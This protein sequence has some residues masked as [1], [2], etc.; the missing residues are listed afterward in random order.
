M[1]TGII[2]TLGKVEKIEI[3]G[4]NIN[5]HILSLFKNQL[6]I[7]QSIAHNGVCLTITKFEDYSYVVTAVQETLFKTN[8]GDLIIGSEV[9]L[10]R[11]MEANGRF[12]GHIV[13]GHVDCIAI[14]LK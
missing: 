6:I 12:D 8:L 10:E 3:D 9:N 11:C 1:F 4:T 14:G 5:F 2:E 7:G 13:Q